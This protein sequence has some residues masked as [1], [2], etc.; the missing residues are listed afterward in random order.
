MNNDYLSHWYSIGE[1]STFFERHL[2]Q[3]TRY[4]SML[5][6]D[7][8]DKSVY[9]SNSSV[10]SPIKSKVV[11]FIFENTMRLLTFMTERVAKLFPH[12]LWRERQT[13]SNLFCQCNK[14][15]FPFA[16]LLFSSLLQLIRSN[17]LRSIALAIVG[18]C[19]R[20]LTRLYGRSYVCPEGCL[21]LLLAWFS[22]YFR[23]HPLV[24][25]I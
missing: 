14:F 3:A 6:V 2:G 18:V 7:A 15:F 5:L 4:R 19:F 23:V 20:W 25:R 17:V 13:L 22:F 8:F 16:S 24:R 11:S 12:W 9:F 10:I 1:R 21:S